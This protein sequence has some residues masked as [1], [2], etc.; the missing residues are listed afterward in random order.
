[1]NPKG[2][3]IGGRP[4]EY[5][6]DWFTK[7]SDY[8]RFVKEDFLIRSF[9]TP[10][11]YGRF[12]SCCITAV[13][14]SRR[15]SYPNDLLHLALSVQN[16]E[17]L[18][19]TRWGVENIFEYLVRNKARFTKHLSNGQRL[20][21]M[22]RRADPK[23]AY[24][25][26]VARGIVDRFQRR[27]RLGRVVGWLKRCMERLRVV[28]Y[29]VLFSGRIG[30]KERARA[31]C[32]RGGRVCLHTIRSQIDYAVSSA[33]TKYGSLGVKVWV[34]RGGLGIQDAGGQGRVSEETKRG[35]A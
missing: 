30:G 13:R 7:F 2:F 8:S 1:V 25:V 29:K 12:E 32:V 3:R 9:F 34:C 5:F 10:S 4:E 11:F 16:P 35:R 31:I 33:R 23:R 17:A 26:L 21:I 18:V 14:I 22:V 15:K 6:S 28:G 24:A 20:R 19:R 27:A